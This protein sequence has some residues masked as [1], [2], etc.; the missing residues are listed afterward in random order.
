[1]CEPPTD[2]WEV[3]S[4]CVFVWMSAS[5]VCVRVCGSQWSQ[6]AVADWDG[7]TEH[8][9]PDCFALVAA[10]TRLLCQNQ[11]RASVTFSHQRSDYMVIVLCY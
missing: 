10:Q 7:A 1:M 11:L 2:G 9:D 5:T 4:W 3:L 6:L 8:R